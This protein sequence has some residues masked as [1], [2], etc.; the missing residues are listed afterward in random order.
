[1]KS[2]FIVFFRKHLLGLQVGV[3]APLLTAHY[4]WHPG[5][6]KCDKNPLAAPRSLLHH[7][8]E[9]IWFPCK[10]LL[11]PL[12]SPKDRCRRYS[13]LSTRIFSLWGNKDIFGSHLSKGINTVEGTHFSGALAVFT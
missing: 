4:A 3:V 9:T 6:F 12:Y 11:C 5:I 8:T 2:K 10:K 1:M 7:P 13:V